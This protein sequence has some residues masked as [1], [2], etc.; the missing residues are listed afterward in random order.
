MFIKVLII[1]NSKLGFKYV[2]ADPRSTGGMPL[3]D[4]A[5]EI[6]HIAIN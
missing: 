5:Q 2:E 1:S 6:E 3:S 4:A